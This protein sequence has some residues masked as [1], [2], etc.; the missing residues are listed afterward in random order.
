M[1][2][3]ILRLLAALAATAVLLSPAVSADL[4]DSALAAQLDAYLE[5]LVASTTQLEGSMEDT[6]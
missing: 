2:K 1:P 5:P 4:D 3:P 6:H